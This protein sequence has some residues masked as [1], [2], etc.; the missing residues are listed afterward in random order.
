M[1]IQTRFKV[2]EDFWVVE[3]AMENDIAE[4]MSLAPLRDK[5]HTAE[6]NT[7]GILEHVVINLAS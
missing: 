4:R 2:V 7:D 1:C 3:G 5:T 6:G